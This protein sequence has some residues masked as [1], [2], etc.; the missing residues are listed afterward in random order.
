MDF[1]EGEPDWRERH[2]EKVCNEEMVSYDWCPGGW[3]PEYTYC[4][5]AKVRGLDKCWAHLSAEQK[6]EYRVGQAKGEEA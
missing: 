6:R 4:W 3:F 1:I 2:P 5:N